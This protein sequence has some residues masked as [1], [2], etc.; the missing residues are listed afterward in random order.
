MS[1]GM[2]YTD[3]RDWNVQDYLN[4]YFGTVHADLKFTLEFMVEAARRL[5]DLPVALDF[6]SGPTVFSGFPLAPRVGEMHFSDY[7]DGNRAA[8][9]AWR[10]G[11]ADA[12]DWRPFVRETLRRET[13][14]EPTE[15][16][17]RAREDAARARAARVLP[18]DAG[19]DDPLGPEYRGF[20]PLVTSHCCAD[21]ATSDKATWR[22]Y[23][24]NIAGL[25]RPGGMLLVS[26]S[27]ASQVYPVGEDRFPGADIHPGDLLAFY[28]GA[29]FADIDLRVRRVP[30][31]ADKGFDTI[32]LISGLKPG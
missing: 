15:A 9:E 25:V 16:D 32:L 22:R 4:D 29:G 8:V 27:G 2:P 11:A 31:R 12:H 21:S 14:T 23:M 30:D 6:G 3:W 26:A 5:P 18:G 13:G 28:E 19:A 10:A 1:S 24:T 17:V 7:L 20:Y